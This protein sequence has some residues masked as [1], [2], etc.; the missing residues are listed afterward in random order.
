MRVVGIP[1]SIV[2]LIIAMQQNTKSK[3]R[4]NNEFKDEFL[5]NSDVHVSSVLSPFQL[6]IMLEALSNEF[7]TGYPCKLQYVDDLKIISESIDMIQID[8]KVNKLRKKWFGTVA[9][10]VLKTLESI[11]MLLAAKALVS[12]Q[13][14]VYTVFTGF[15]KDS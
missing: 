5:V 2:T 8:L 4:I 15:T 9:R 12:I 6:I 11:R 1:E 7:R 3:V 14:N 10:A 13:S